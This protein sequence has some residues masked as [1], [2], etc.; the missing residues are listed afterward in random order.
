MLNITVIFTTY[1]EAHNI[2]A[3][4]DTVVGWANEIIV[5]DS[6]STD[7]T[8]KIVSDTEGGDKTSIKLLQRAYK[9]PA[10]QKN[11]AI[12]QAKNAWIL[13]VDADER[14]TDA[15]KTEIEQ[16]VNAEN[17][18]ADAYWIGFQH[19]FM[20]K[21]VRYSGWQNDKTIRLIQRDK[22]RYNSNQV[23]EEIDTKGLKIG[24]LTHKFMHY[25]F[26]DLDHFV[27]KQERYAAWSA[28]DYAA[29]TPRVTFFHLA[30]KP[31][32]RFFK[33]YILKLGFLDGK[34]GFFIASIA[35]W[36]V[37]L[38]FAKIVEMRKQKKET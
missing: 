1:N 5:V 36:T 15:L 30:I 20:G 35:A 19:Y 33:H 26:K 12:P 13:L 7:A 21:K 32:F 14:V 16:V 28:L 38:R 2:A 37:F 6:F 29:K 18:T 24:R 27:A 17:T 11:W 34:V 25:T 9:G 31:F 3:A 23:H 22:C 10:D 4:L 8:C